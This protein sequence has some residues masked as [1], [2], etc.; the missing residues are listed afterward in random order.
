MILLIS[1]VTLLACA[2]NVFAQSAIVTPNQV[3]Q[4]AYVNGPG[5][6]T[7][8]N[9]FW[10][11]IAI[12]LVVNGDG[13]GQT[14]TINLPSNIT[15]ADATGGGVDANVSLAWTGTGLGAD[16]AVNAA[17]DDTHIVVTQNNATAAADWVLNVMFPI[18]TSS[19]ASGTEDYT[20]DFSNVAF[21]D[22]SALT[23]TYRAAGALQVVDFLDNMKADDDSTTANDYIGL[24]YPEPAAATY[25][26]LPDLVTDAAN[27]VYSGVLAAATDADNT[28][29]VT[30]SVWASTDSTLSHV[31][32]FQSGVIQVENHTTPGFF[33]QNEGAASSDAYYTGGLPEGEYYFYITSDFTG[34]FPIARSGKLTV[35]HFPH[36][37]IAGW[38]RTGNGFDNSGGHADDADLTL[39]TGQFLDVDGNSPAAPNSRTDTDLYVS[40]DDLDDNARL[41]IFYS[42]TTSLT[43][44][45]VVTSGTD[46]NMVITGVTGA[47][48]LVDTLYENDEDVE[49][50]IAWNWDINPATDGSYI[51]GGDYAM[52]AVACDGKHFHFIRFNGTQ[53][54][55]GEVIKLR[56]SPNLTIDVLSEYDLGDDTGNNA[57]VTID[58]GLTDEIMISWG[59]SGVTGDIDVDDSAL[60]EFYLVYDTGQTGNAL[61]GNDVVGVINTIR[62][63][64]SAAQTPTGVHK[65]FD[66]KLEDLEA[67]DQSWFAWNLSEDFAASGWYPTDEAAAAGPHYYQLYAIMDEN[68]SGGTQRL[69]ALG[70]DGIVTQGEAITTIEFDNR[71]GIVRLLDPPAEGVTVDAAQTYMFNFTAFDMDT[72]ANVGIFLVQKDTVVDGETGPVTTMMGLT[73]VSGLYATGNGEA[74]C[75]TD[76]DGDPAAGGAWLTDN[77]STSYEFTL[78]APGGT[79]IYTNS[80]NTNAT[81]LADGQYWVYIGIDDGSYYSQALTVG[82]SV[83]FRTG[84]WVTS[85]SGAQGYVIAIPDGTHLTVAA[86]DQLFVAENLDIG[87]TYVAAETAISAAAAAVAQT[88][89]TNAIVP[90]HRAPGLV[91]IVNAAVSS[92]QRN[93]TIS[94]M[95]L[96]VAQGDTATYTGQGCR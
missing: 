4:G 78:Q 24:S 56:H 11:H 8:D 76:D 25:G 70:S 17:T 14:I 31:S 44:A 5:G 45:D 84:D 16:F 86:K 46:G 35:L 81:A 89:F 66:G 92:P 63:A 36:I 50:F 73:G 38:D 7:D 59:K 93:M 3:P 95:K 28:N 74:Y 43:Q 47:T 53:A 55:A 1:L 87:L 10:Q 90:L 27:V 64:S 33:T 69:L 22:I 61:Y 18:E 48:A 72:D 75:L 52:Y 20:I 21:T 12:S 83:T 30:Y 2:G 9:Y 68:K 51:Q 29:D 15:L 34:D 41:Y 13:A 32:Q 49:G 42:S 79:N 80:V 77:S 88:E 37:E 85:A 67:K 60:I 6:A 96:T 82:S 19:I 58:P 26:A 23:V 62:T 65:I 94:P 40:V 71:A 54:D 91:N 57:N 39:D